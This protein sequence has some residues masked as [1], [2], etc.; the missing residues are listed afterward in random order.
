MG[1]EHDFRVNNLMLF[2]AVVF[3]LLV[4]LGKQFFSGLV[5]SSGNCGIALASLNNSY[6]QMGYWHFV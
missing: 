5:G 4:V 1:R 2:S 6:V 3:V